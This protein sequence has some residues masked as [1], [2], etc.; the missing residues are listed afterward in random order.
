VPLV[1]R[2]LTGGRYIPNPEAQGFDVEALVQN[3]EPR[4]ARRAGHSIWDT[5]TS[6]EEKLDAVESTSSSFDTT[7]EEDRGVLLLPL[8][9]DDIWAHPEEDEEGASEQKEQQAPE[10]P[11]PSPEKPIL[12]PARP[13]RSIS[14]VD[15]ELARM[16]QAQEDVEILGFLAGAYQKAQ[17]PVIL[18]PQVAE[19][20]EP[21]QGLPQLRP[22][23]PPAIDDGLLP[24]EL[25]AARRGG[26]CFLGQVE[27]AVRRYERE[28]PIEVRAH[29]ERGTETKGAEAGEGAGAPEIAAVISGAISGIAHSFF[30]C[31]LVSSSSGAAERPASEIICAPDGIAQ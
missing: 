5:H 2:L 6:A 15:E 25:L 22:Q 21:L 14:S 13:E 28:A 12:C 30:A 17:G 24:A 23:R 3:L 1:F 16:L 19:S 11:I 26:G 8:E 20:V 27:A 10:K 18:Q 7:V 9:S 4:S 31:G 29:R